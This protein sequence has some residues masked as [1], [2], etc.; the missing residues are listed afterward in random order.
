[1]KLNWGT[2]IVITFIVFISFILYF[3]VKT[4][5]QKQYDY[6]LVTESYYE[7]ELNF[8][9]TIDY[10]KNTKELFEKV[11]LLQEGTTWVAKFPKQLKGHVVGEI[12]FYRPSNDL[13]DFVTKANN[14]RVEI[15]STS[16]VPGRW[17]AIITWYYSQEPEMKFYQ[18][19]E[20]YY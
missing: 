4:F 19:E 12:Q 14:Y 8:Q 17:N 5:T 13:L 2:Y 15:P 16:L 3:V 20:F 1:M 10:A 7:E 11:Q 6:D 18:K 9:Q